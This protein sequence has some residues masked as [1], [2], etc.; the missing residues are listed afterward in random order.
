MNS[1]GGQVTEQ[2]VLQ[3]ARV[4]MHRTAVAEAIR[5]VSAFRQTLG[6]IEALQ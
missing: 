1:K 2:H 6:V 5:V 4:C 3:D